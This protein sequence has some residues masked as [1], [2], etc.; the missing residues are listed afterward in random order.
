[1]KKLL[2]IIPFLVG[3]LLAAYVDAGELPSEWRP[4]WQWVSGGAK[5][6]AVGHSLTVVEW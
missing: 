6:L 4:T 3:I 5:A 1:M 2:W